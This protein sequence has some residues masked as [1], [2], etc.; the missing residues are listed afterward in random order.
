MEDTPDGSNVAPEGQSVAISDV[1]ATVVPASEIITGTEKELAERLVGDN[2]GK[3]VRF[4]LAALSSIPG[5]GLISAFSN[6]AAEAD[7]ETV[8]DLLRMWIQE[9][10]EK[11]RELGITVE[12]ILKR[13]DKFGEEVH[14]RLED[15]AYLALVRQTFRSWNDAATQDKRQMFKQLITNAGA[16]T[17]CPDSLVRLF[18]TWLNQYHEDH[19]Q[20]IKQI[21]ENKGITRGSIWDHIHSE[22]PRENS[23]EA[24]LYRYLIR[25]LSTGGVIRQSRETNEYGEFVRQS[26]K[27]TRHSSGSS[28]STMESSFEDT[29]PYELTGLGSQFV[30]YVMTEADPQLGDGIAR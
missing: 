23:A 26:T 17:L 9:Q 1:N 25:E 15:P 3:Y 14:K 16:I 29:K 22:R 7:Q 27:G 28:S 6:L 30:R 4:A 10:K 20:V 2:G 8:N 12:D 13:L 24:D 21:Y 11:I 18:I 19:F 5:V